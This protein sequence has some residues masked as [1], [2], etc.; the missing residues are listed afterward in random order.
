MRYYSS[1]G[2]E[3]NQRNNLDLQE[4]NEHS[5]KLLQNYIESASKDV[6]DQH[7]HQTYD[8]EFYVQEQ[9]NSPV[10]ICLAPPS[11][12][13]PEATRKSLSKLFKALGID[14]L[15]EQ[16]ASNA[17]TWNDMPLSLREFIPMVHEAYMLDC[18][19]ASSPDVELRTLKTALH[20]SRRIKIVFAEDIDG[21]KRSTLG[22]IMLV[23]SLI[24]IMPE[25]APSLN[26]LS[27]G[28]GS[29]CT[30]DE[31]TGIVWLNAYIEA[32]EWLRFLG[33]V[34]LQKCHDALEKKAAIR[35]LSD[36]VASLLGVGLVYGRD[37]K[38]TLSE[39]YENL[40]LSVLE[41]PP[42]SSEKYPNV[43]IQFVEHPLHDDGDVIRCKDG[44]ITLHLESITSH[45]A[46]YDI[47]NTSILD[48][49]TEQ[50]RRIQSHQSQMNDLKKHVE[51]KLRLRLLAHDP[52][53]PD[54]KFKAACQKLLEHAIEV[55]ISSHN[56]ILYDCLNNCI[57]LTC[58]VVQL[59]P[60]LEGLKL[61][62]T[63]RNAYVKGRQCIDIS[64]CFRL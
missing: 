51:K 56:N 58:V 38:V 14:E 7:G 27:V 62:I 12:S 19:D 23:Q 22:K 55:C 46:L 34:D 13:A 6:R 11:A 3:N 29:A 63:D 35:M 33:N 25:C 18:V 20:F 40:L 21:S 42:T 4:T 44:T 36:Q 64:W 32:N 39:S 24:D 10:S 47:L 5:F 57:I 45:H 2:E 9:G 53:V 59:M 15:E 41:H 8:F 61:R 50:A 17:N 31:Y 26:G 16:Q 43:S 30:V 54:F 28:F 48:E 60:L 49:A 1:Q 52:K 37:P